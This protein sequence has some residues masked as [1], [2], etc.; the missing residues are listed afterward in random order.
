MPSF[1][2]V[3]EINQHEL[4]NA[5]DQANREINNRFDFKNIKALFELT[6]DT[7]TLSAP[8]DFQVKQMQPILREKFAKRNLDA[9]FLEFKDISQSLSEARQEVQ[10]KK[11]IDK[12]LAKKITK[13]I[14][15]SK[16]K[17]QSQIQG[18]QMRV[19]GK[20]RDDLQAV[21]ALLRKEELEQPL[22]FENFRD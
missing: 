21:M 1:D 13:L 4:S 3:S 7:I 2:I 20:S 22:Q 18:E 10:I 8:N 14:K 11:G 16:L 9:R 19:T 6:K 5:V 12:E 15:D 17:V